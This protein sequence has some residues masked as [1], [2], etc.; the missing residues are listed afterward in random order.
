MRYI[1]VRPSP[2]FLDHPPETIDAE[3]LEAM[4]NGFLEALPCIR[5]VAR[6]RLLHLAE[7]RK[8]EEIAEIIALSWKA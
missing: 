3:M 1:P 2:L 4:Q 6:F 7:E 8:E 5:C